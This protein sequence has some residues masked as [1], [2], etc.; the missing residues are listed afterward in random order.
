M[1]ILQLAIT[2]PKRGANCINDHCSSHRHIM[3]QASTSQRIGDA[4]HPNSAS[5][6]SLSR[7]CKTLAMGTQRMTIAEMHELAR[8]TTV[9]QKFLEHVANRADKVLFRSMT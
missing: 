8:D 7:N 9:P 3:V 4:S 5:V 2:T 6:E 1:P